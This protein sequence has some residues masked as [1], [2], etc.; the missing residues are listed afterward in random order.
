MS[1]AASR[2]EEATAF[3][4]ETLKEKLVPAEFGI[5]LRSGILLCSIKINLSDRPFPQMENI[6][7]YV[8]VCRQLGVPESAIFVTIDLFEMRDVDQVARNVIAVKRV[9][10]KP[11]TISHSRAVSR[12]PSGEATVLV[13]PRV[14]MLREATPVVVEASPNMTEEKPKIVEIEVN[15]TPKA[16]PAQPPIPLSS[17]RERVTPKS[18]INWINHSSSRENNVKRSSSRTMSNAPPAPVIAPRRKAEETKIVNTISHDRKEDIIADILSFERAKQQTLPQQK[19]P[20]ALMEGQWTGSHIPDEIMD[21]RDIV[22]NSSYDFL[23]ED[24]NALLDKFPT[25][26]TVNTVYNPPEPITAA[27]PSERLDRS[28]STDANHPIQAEMEAFEK[29]EFQRMLKESAKLKMQQ[30]AEAREKLM[31]NRLEQDKQRQA[32]AKAEQNYGRHSLRSQ[33]RFIY[34]TSPKEECAIMK[35]SIDLQKFVEIERR[36]SESFGTQ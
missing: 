16:S 14:R 21:L 11:A 25:P 17:S 22:R 19:A 2:I 29:A 36:K 34:N 8:Q 5:K 27:T 10:E 9:T 7:A 12:K 35:A 33:Q 32:R 28:K 6:A 23:L 3:I 18:I 30:K 13:S 31:R 4:S 15:R 1:S 26:P 20:A 24:L